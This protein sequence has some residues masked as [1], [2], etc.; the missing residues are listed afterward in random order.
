M[1]FMYLRRLILL[2]ML[3]GLL[4]GGAV[5]A[6]DDTTD[7]DVLD[8]TI[9]QLVV[10][11]SEQD[12][13]EFTVL[14]E[15]LESVDLLE[16]LDDEE[17]SYMVFAP[18]DAAFE[19]LE[20]VLGVEM[21][22]VLLLTDFTEEML[23]YHVSEELYTLEE[24]RDQDSVS[25]LQGQSIDV[26]YNSRQEML[27]LDGYAFVIDGDIAL[28]NG[29]V[30]VIDE[31]LFPGV[32][33]DPADEDT[34]DDNSDTTEETTGSDESDEGADGE[35]C[36]VRTDEA[37]S[38]RVR[39]GP[40]TNRTAVTFL[41]EGEDLVVQGQTDIDGDTWYRLNVEDAAPGRAIN[42]AWVPA[43]NLQ[44]SGD[45]ENIADA[46]APPVV[47]IINQPPPQTGGD[48][49]GEGGA[50]PD[51]TGLIRPASGTWSL[52]LVPTTNAS[53]EGTGNIQIPT[54][55]IFFQTSFRE[56]VRP[57]GDSFIMTGTSFTF[58]GDNT[59]QAQET[60][61]DLT[62]TLYVTFSSS[63]QASGRFITSFTTSDGVGCSA[64]VGF[65]MSR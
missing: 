57:A 31:V 40:G 60:F 16:T 26:D 50:A 19:S 8:V 43:E 17:A 22:T 58:I 47:P 44:T 14:R 38:V 46:D 62:G 51:T 28:N 30:H 39:V 10:E 5:F 55:E 42:E 59:H 63:T 33:D 12:E 20:E 61:D 65:T 49:N 18:S 35:P 9:A 24:L 1:F 34:A 27:V 52:T 48:D 53:C 54:D 7:T 37:D 13:P 29:V 6:Q 45:C 2:V 64:T 32:D 15:A 41:P 21:D 3:A 4:A 11:S 25:T 36:I 23:F 56:S